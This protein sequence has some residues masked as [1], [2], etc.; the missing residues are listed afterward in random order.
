MHEA[1]LAVLYEI[2]IRACIY[3]MHTMGQ[4]NCQIVFL[5]LLNLILTYY[6]SP[7]HI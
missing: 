4:A 3:W 2:M 5:T 1:R 6:L 7:F